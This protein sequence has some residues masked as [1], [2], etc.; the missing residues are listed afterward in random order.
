MEYETKQYEKWS[1]V[2]EFKLHPYMNKGLGT[3]N[4][5]VYLTNSS[6]QPNGSNF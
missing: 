3:D 5:G 4:P 2:R 6:I 1:R